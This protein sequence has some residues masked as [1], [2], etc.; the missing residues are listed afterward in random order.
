VRC[1]LEDRWGD[2]TRRALGLRVN[3]EAMGKGNTR[4]T[5]I[6]RARTEKKLPSERVAK[7]GQHGHPSAALQVQRFYQRARRLHGVCQA[8]G[9]RTRERQVGENVGESVQDASLAAAWGR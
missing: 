9:G 4:T 1:P 6:I 2:V 8:H 3:Y 7:T 5:G